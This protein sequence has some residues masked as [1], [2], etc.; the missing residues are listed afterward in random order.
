[1]HHIRLQVALAK[2]GITSR[3]KAAGLIASN[4]LRVNGRI[5]DKRGFRVDIA[6]DRISLD[7]V[8]IHFRE[9]KKY[10][11]L[12]KP[13]GVLSAVSDTRR[14]K[15][16]ID[17]LNIGKARIYPVGRLDKDTTGLIILTDDGELTYRLTHP[18]FN[19]D[20]VYRVTVEGVVRERDTLPLRKGIV[21]EGKIARVKSIT[22]TKGK[23]GYT[24]MLV[25]MGEGRKREIRNLFGSIGCTVTELKR[26]AYGSLRLG[27]LKE[28]EYRALTESEVKKL[29]KSVGLK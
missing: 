3:R 15:T 2:A 5:V 20:R 10:F 1:M 25:T 21:I 6:N 27:E 17:C 26:I 19:I 22:F 7:N 8:E 18:K 16:V 13:A 14:R 28:G 24:T 4:R 23:S 12:H 9:A 29:R 11:I